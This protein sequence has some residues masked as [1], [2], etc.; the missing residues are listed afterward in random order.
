MVID[1]IKISQEINFMGMPTWIGIEGT[2]VPD[3]DVLESLKKVQQHITDYDNAAKKEYSKSKWAKGNPYADP[4][5]KPLMDMIVLRQYQKAILEKDE[6]TI[7]N[8]K[9]QYHVED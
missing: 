7:N 4:E 2:L 6:V 9:A 8:I 3:E 5:A 1:R